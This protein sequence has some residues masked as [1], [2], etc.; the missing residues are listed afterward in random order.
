M[1]T[2]NFEPQPT[3]TGILETERLRL[4]CFTLNDSA[5]IIE[6]LNSPGWLEFIGD[7]KV[8][9]EEQAQWYL[10]SGPLQS[11]EQYGFG[12]WLVELKNEQTPIGICGILKRNTLEHP[13]IGFASLPAFT[14][15]GYAFEIA[16]ATLAFA[17][18][19]LHLPTIL[20]ITVPHNQASIRLLEKI[21]LSY[22][23]TIN[24]ADTDEKL[25]LYSTD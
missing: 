10:R 15:K 2:S 17:K 11:Y 7:R 19:T 13:D 16:S 21:G 3:M 18:N 24:H 23:Q 25:L 22:Q 8:K 6:L 1:K 5:F 20:A 9:K 4:R 12:M 14:G